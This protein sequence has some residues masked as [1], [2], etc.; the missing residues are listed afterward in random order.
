MGVRGVDEQYR[1]AG[2]RMFLD[3]G[4]PT[5]RALFLGRPNVGLAVQLDGIGTVGAAVKAY[6]PIESAPRCLRQRV[7]GRAHVGEHGAALGRRHLEGVEDSQPRQRVLIGLVGVPRRGA[8]HPE[9]V[10]PTM[11]VP[12]PRR[13]FVTEEY[14]RE[15]STPHARL[16]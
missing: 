15:P 12:S 7:V 9:P 13:L 16:H 6:Q 4:V 14:I 5:L 3:G 1:A 10:D 8:Y 11:R 2:H